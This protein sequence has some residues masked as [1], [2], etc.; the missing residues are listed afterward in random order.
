[1]EN[2]QSGKVITILLGVLLVAVLGYTFYSNAENEKM[3]AD[4][5]TEKAEIKSDLNKMIAQYD[6]KLA[7]GTS[8]KAKLTAA[9]KDI[10]TYRDSLTNEK[11]ISYNLIRRS[12][13][14]VYSLDAKNK[15]LFA[16]LEALRV[17]NKKLNTEIVVAKETIETQ[18]VENAKLTGENKV[19]VDKVAI[20]AVLNISNLS[21]VAMKKLSSGALKETNRYRK[22]DA[23]RI[24]FKIN[25]NELTLSGDKPAYFVIKDAAGTVVSAKGKININGSELYYSDTTVIDYQNIDTEVIIITDV[26]RKE[27]EKGAYTISA[28]LDGK[29][30]GNTTVQLKE[31]FLGVF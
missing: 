30:V 24:S 12:K 17:E 1:M 21:A 25:K 23:F 6:A 31:S 18:A 9:R 3:T 2:K 22:T 4:L 5:E 11:K 15:A 14:R 7:E 20:G 29:A 26:N 13:N 8:L 16:E 27:T 19:L 10:I 28:F